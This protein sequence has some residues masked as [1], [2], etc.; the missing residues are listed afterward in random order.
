VL[1]GVV[2]LCTAGRLSID[3]VRSDDEDECVRGL[4]TIDD[5]VAPIR[6]RDKVLV[7]EDLL[8]M[9]YKR[10]AKLPCEI[11]GT[12]A[13]VRNENA[14][15]TVTRSDK[16][17]LEGHESVAVASPTKSNLAQIAFP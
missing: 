3:G 10:F 2:K 13:R 8:P 6:G 1:D 16:L 15:H 9:P 5:L 12:E 14:S 7:R 4:D 11:S 17:V